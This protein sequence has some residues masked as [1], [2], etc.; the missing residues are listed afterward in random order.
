[1]IFYD[2]SP[3]EAMLEP[4]EPEQEISLVRLLRRCVM[5]VGPGETSTGEAFIWGEEPAHI[6][7]VYGWSDEPGFNFAIRA[8]AKYLKDEYRRPRW[9]AEHE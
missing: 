1:V 5:I 8:D 3:W 2:F 7:E 4:P 9:E 6:Q